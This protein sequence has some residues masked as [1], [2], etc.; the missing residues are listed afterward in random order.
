[1]NRVQHLIVAKD[2]TASG[3]DGFIRVVKPDGTAL[4]PGESITDVPV[5]HLEQD[6]ASGK[7]LSPPIEGA[8]VRSWKGSSNAAATAQVTHVGNIGS[9]TLDIDANNSTEYI[10]RITLR[11]DRDV[12][13][14]PYSF[15]YVSDAS[16]TP[17][18]IADA[19]VSLINNAL[20]VNNDDTTITALKVNNGADF[21][22]SLTGG[23]GSAETYFKVTLDGGFGDTTVT[24]TTAYDPGSG[25]SPWTVTLEGFTK[26]YVG[27]S[28][29]RTR[30]GDKLVNP[31]LYV[32]S[33]EGYDVYSL[34]FGR[35]HD[36]QYINA[37]KVA[38]LSL[39]ILVPAGP[40]NFP[41]ALFESIINPWLASSPAA[42]ASVSL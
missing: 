40:S 11:S 27:D 23:T 14:V 42:L 36:E 9:G 5:I 32:D 39:Y 7:L 28:M 29:Q 33:T 15:Y 17:E 10:L 18:E 20:F 3:T 25:N 41:Q 4:A 24:E 34:D 26:G 6:L 31:T 30:W 22:F 2:V 1:M 16:A 37:S 21:G 35:S 8:F 12:K 13:D 38:P 19:F